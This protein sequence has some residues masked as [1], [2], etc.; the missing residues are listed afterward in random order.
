MGLL[1]NDGSMATSP[2]ATA[3]LLSQV[4]DWRSRYPKSVDYLEGLIARCDAGLPPIVP[5]GVFVRAW[6]LYYLHHHGNLLA[7]RDEL[8]RANCEHLLE[9]WGPGG[10]GWSSNGLP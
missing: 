3:F 9:R 6:P 10:L 4:P 5:S 7:G 1:L 2:S 8:V